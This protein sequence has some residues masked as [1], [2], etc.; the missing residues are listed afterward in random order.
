MIDSMMDRR[1]R[2]AA[3]SSAVI[4]DLDDAFVEDFDRISLLGLRF[5]SPTVSD[6]AYM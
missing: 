4:L 1:W 5:D 3:R 2:I 6:M